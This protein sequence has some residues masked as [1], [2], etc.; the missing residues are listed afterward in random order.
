[1]PFKKHSTD[2]PTPLQKMESKKLATNVADLLGQYQKSGSKLIRPDLDGFLQIAQRKTISATKPPLFLLYKTLHQMKYVSSMYQ[3]QGQEDTYKI[4]WQGQIA[5][6]QFG[7]TSG[8]ISPMV[9]KSAL[10]IHSTFVTKIV[11]SEDKD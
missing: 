1:M 5:F 4:E 8:T 6:V 10:Y 11:T 2:F 9:S 7:A 3:V